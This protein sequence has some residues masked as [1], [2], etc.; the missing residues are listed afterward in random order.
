MSFIEG[1]RLSHGALYLETPEEDGEDDDYV[2]P[3]FFEPPQTS[4]F[5]PK[6]HSLAIV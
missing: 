1:S 5:V 4:K 6:G 2:P 3:P